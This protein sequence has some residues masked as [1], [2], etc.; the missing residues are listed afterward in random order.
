MKFLNCVFLNSYCIDVV[1]FEVV[2][3]VSQSFYLSINFTGCYIHVV[4]RFTGENR[5][6][7]FSVSQVSVADWQQNFTRIE[8]VTSYLLMQNAIQN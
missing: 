5:L 7:T 8:N 4:G 2:V 6:H 3:K 1:I